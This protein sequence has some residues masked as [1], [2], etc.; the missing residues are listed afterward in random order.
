MLM[1]FLVFIPFSTYFSA[2]KN[3]FMHPV[4]HLEQNVAAGLN[5]LPTL[6][7]LSIMSLYSQTISIPFAKHICTSNDAFLNRLDLGP[8][9][10]RIK[11]H[12]AAVINYPNL[13]LGREASHEAGTL[14]GGGG[15]TRMQLSSFGP[16]KIP[17]P[18]YEKF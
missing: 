9:Y 6:M 5:D 18:T 8:G 7:E 10:D 2:S 1:E 11:Q 3:P 12:M 17:S 13:L 15:I 14:Y 16:I 4:N